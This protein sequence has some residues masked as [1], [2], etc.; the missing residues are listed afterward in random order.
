MRKRP[1]AALKAEFIA[2]AAAERR[3]ALPLD[4]RASRCG[5]RNKRLMTFSADRVIH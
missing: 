2:R 5:W 1:G 3:E 4:D